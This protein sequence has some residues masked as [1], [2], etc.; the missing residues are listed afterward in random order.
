MTPRDA[1]DYAEIA[2]VMARYFR[3]M[4]TWDYDIL[5]MVFTPDAKLRYEA[6]EGADTDYDG[7]LKQFSGFNCYFSF[8]QHM[9]S[10]LVIELD[11]DQAVARSTLRAIHV[12]TLR[13]GGENEWV[14]YGTYRDEL[15]RTE[16][17]WRIAQRHFRTTRT[18]GRL[19]P[20]DACERYESPPW[21]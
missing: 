10:Q 11:G 2:Q 4:D 20:F 16:E 13:Q 3:A 9:S 8:M 19:V 1:S 21:L 5:A 15:V 17:G 14:I 12:Q 18:T 6:L 7:M